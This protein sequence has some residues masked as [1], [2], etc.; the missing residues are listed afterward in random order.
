MSADTTTISFKDAKGFVISGGNFGT[1]RGNVITVNSGASGSV[2]RSHR[3]KP[4]PHPQHESRQAEDPNGRS[5][6]TSS[7]REPSRGNRRARARTSRAPRRAPSPSVSDGQAALTDVNSCS[8]PNPPSDTGRTISG[9]GH[10]LTLPT[11]PPSRP[12]SIDLPQSSLE[13]PSAG[14][15]WIRTSNQQQQG[16]FAA[17]LDASEMQDVPRF[18]VPES[19]MPTVNWST[20]PVFDDGY[21]YRNQQLTMYGLYYG[22]AGSASTIHSPSWSF[23]G[24]GPALSYHTPSNTMV[25]S[26][27]NSITPQPWGSAQPFL[28]AQRHSRPLPPIPRTKSTSNT[29]SFQGHPIGVPSS[30]SYTSHASHDYTGHVPHPVPLQNPSHYSARSTHINEAG[31]L[32]PVHY[33]NVPYMT[34]VPEVPSGLETEDHAAVFSR[35]QSHNM[36]LEGNALGLIS[37]APS[38]DA[39]YYTPQISTP[40]TQAHLQD[41]GKHQSGSF[42]GGSSSIYEGTRSSYSCCSQACWSPHSGHPMYHV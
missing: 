33:T 10:N 35:L 22:A 17:P 23:D 9:A 20:Q 38:R 32:S 40:Q 16:I 1:V 5:S 27:G 14:V 12:S 4:T 31:W 18:Q 30:S 29:N 3:P 34:V 39:I 8:R 13:S 21:A 19:C 28:P 15:G 24:V 26:T 2:S 6:A 37:P 25:Y 42:R 7:H 11:P 41:A 36:L